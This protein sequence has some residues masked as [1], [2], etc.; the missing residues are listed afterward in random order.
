MVDVHHEKTGLTLTLTLT[1]SLATFITVHFIKIG[2]INES[3]DAG[4]VI[5]QTYIVRSLDI[6]TNGLNQTGQ[7]KQNRSSRK[8][9]SDLK[10]I[11]S[12]LNLD[13]ADL[14]NLFEIS[15]QDVY[16]LIGRE[17]TPDTTGDGIADAS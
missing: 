7:N 16:K 1:L 11:R 15:R 8:K 2:T 5:C 10:K 6:K 17:L 14:A 9:Q 13:I 12:A 4:Q 3:N